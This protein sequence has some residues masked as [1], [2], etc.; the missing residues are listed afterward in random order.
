MWFQML[1]TLFDKKLQVDLKFIFQ[2]R[3][4]K[5]NFF[6]QIEICNPKKA[7]T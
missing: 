2:F 5:R 1:Q 4:G 3:F 7:F 6:L